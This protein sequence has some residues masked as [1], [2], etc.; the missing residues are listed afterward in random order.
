[1]GKYEGITMTKRI[2]LESPFAN[3]DNNKFIE[4]YFYLCLVAR[5]LMKK[6]NHS[7]LFFHA[8]Y[9]QFLNDRDKAERKLGLYNSFDWH[10]HGDFKLYAIDRGFSDGMLKGALDAIEKNIDI[11]FFTALPK[12]HWISNKID[13]INKEELNEKRLELGQKFISTLSATSTTF[14][15]KGELTE[16]KDYNTEYFSDIKDCILNFFAPIVDFIRAER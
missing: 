15:S 13:E 1:M 10:T 11:F 8:L 2:I 7:P 12:D 4:N 3:N 16:Y 5:I 9:T 14:E 6:G